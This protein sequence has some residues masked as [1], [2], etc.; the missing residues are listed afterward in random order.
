MAERL[1][2]PVDACL[3]LER[4]GKLLMLRRAPGAYAAGLLCRA[5]TWRRRN[6]WS[7]E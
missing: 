3:L 6:L 5:A 4:G 1:C 2:Y 7:R